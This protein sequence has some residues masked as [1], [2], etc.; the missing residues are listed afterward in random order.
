MIFQRD[1]CRWESRAG[2]LFIRL[3]QRISTNFTNLFYLWG[4]KKE[5]D[6]ELATDRE[7]LTGH[8]LSEKPD[9]SQ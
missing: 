9:Y 4:I 5:R 7:T 2:C 1:K 6:D 3:F 8:Y